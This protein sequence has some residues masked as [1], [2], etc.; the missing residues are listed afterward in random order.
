[1]AWTQAKIPIA[2]ELAEA[3]G[4]ALLGA[5]AA[6]VAI[7]DAHGGALD[8][9][10]LYAE[11]GDGRSRVWKESVVVALF[12][13]DLDAARAVGHAIRSLGMTAAPAFRTER[14]DDQDWV[15]LTQSQFGAIQISRRLWVVPSWSEV[16]DPRAINLLLDPGQAFGT[17]SHPTTRL[18]AQWLDRHLNRGDRVLDYGCGSGILAIAA[19]KLGALDVLGVDIDPVAVQVARANG[20]ANGVIAAFLT[21]DAM[22]PVE[23]DVTVA[24]ILANPLIVLAP[25]LARSTRVGGSIALSGILKEQADSVAAAYAPSFAIEPAAE[26][27][28]WVLLAGIK[29]R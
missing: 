21:L 12:N 4:D 17:G 18:C 6:S 9:E 20:L 11:P 19:A 5:G 23:A 10:P 26:E 2:G 3:L 16:P 24:N 22:P 25:L 13:E 7:E 27:E 1:M 15:K 28:G 8:E 29:V 14:V